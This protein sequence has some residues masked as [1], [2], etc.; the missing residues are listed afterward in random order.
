MLDLET[1]SEKIEF[2]LGMGL[3]LGKIMSSQSTSRRKMK[4]E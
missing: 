1:K 4:Y 3:D 2:K